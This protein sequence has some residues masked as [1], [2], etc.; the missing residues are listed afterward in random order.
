MAIDTD[1]ESELAAIMAD[2]AAGDGAALHRLIAAHRPQLARLVVAIA[3]DRGARPN[4]EM[5][6]ELVVEAAL[7]VQEVA[8]AWKPGGAPPWIW[9]RRRVAAAVDRHLG[10][11]ADELQPDQHRDVAAPPPAPSTESSTAE[12]LARLGR[13]NQTVAL[14]RE[15]LELVASPRDQLVFVEMGVQFALGDPSPAVT[16]G[17]LFGMKPASVRQQSRRT[18]VRLQALAASDD[19]FQ[20]LASLALVA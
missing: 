8:G 12:C 4:G 17:A 18:R 20:P 13:E 5:V 7:A 1:P 6:D 19:R 14:L 2:L 15:G 3:A 16:V 11:W 10:I 9:A